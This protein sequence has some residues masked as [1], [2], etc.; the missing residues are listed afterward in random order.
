MTV[1]RLIYVILL[2]PY[3]LNTVLI[4]IANSS[5]NEEK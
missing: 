3:V 1:V 2:K 5:D 4:S